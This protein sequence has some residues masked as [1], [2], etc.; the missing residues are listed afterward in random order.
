VRRKR[1]KKGALI[2][3]DVFF[4]G[5]LVAKEIYPTRSMSGTPAEGKKK[6][7]IQANELKVEITTT[8]TARKKKRELQA[9]T[10][11]PCYPRGGKTALVCP[12]CKVAMSKK[13]AA[14]RAL[15]AKMS[16]MGWILGKKLR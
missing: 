7:D 1:K 13:P 9:D 14:N 15:R 6:K 11:T 2:W 12:R 8:T 3:K 5:V 16:S 4:R 10:F